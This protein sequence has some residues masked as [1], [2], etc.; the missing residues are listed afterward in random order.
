MNERM[1]LPLSP[2][3]GYSRCWCCMR[4]NQ[5]IHRMM[6]GTLRTVV[7]IWQY[8]RSIDRERERQSTV[9]SL[10]LTKRLLLLS[11]C[12]AD[13]AIVVSQLL[14]GAARTC[15]PSH[16]NFH[17]LPPIFNVICTGI[18]SVIIII[19]NIHTAHTSV[20]FIPP[21]TTNWRSVDYVRVCAHVLGARD[22]EDLECNYI[23]QSF[24]AAKRT[25]SSSGC[26]FNS[27]SHTTKSWREESWKKKNAKRKT[28]DSST[29]NLLGDK[30]CGIIKM[31]LNC[32]LEQS[33]AKNKEPRDE[34]RERCAEKMEY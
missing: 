10:S 8:L 26:T 32:S 1:A 2:I 3:V 12:A 18:T 19:I 7:G 24:D 22:E 6:R 14:L 28:I 23:F 13:S 20:Y 17:P 29:W 30:L 15:S 9:L 5:K 4:A 21:F 27:I 25:W 34:A 11:T 16:H 31:N 33:E